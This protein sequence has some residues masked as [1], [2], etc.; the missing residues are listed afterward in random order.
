MQNTISN[1][2]PGPSSDDNIHCSICRL[3]NSA[4]FAGFEPMFHPG[5]TQVKYR[6]VQ[7]AAFQRT[8][9]SLQEE[10]TW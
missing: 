2:L 8:A 10:S 1:W 6:L 3:S 5:A 7:T 4:L 9:A